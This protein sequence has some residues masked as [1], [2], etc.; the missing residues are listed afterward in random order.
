MV[1]L[2][3]SKSTIL[4]ISLGRGVMM[5]MVGTHTINSK[6][7][8]LKALIPV[9]FKMICFTFID[10][11]TPWRSLECVDGL[12]HSIHLAHSDASIDSRVDRIALPVR[13]D[14]HHQA[15]SPYLVLR[16]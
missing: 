10:G 2:R 3:R 5:T 6:M 16:G 7:N 15:L 11:C 4:S 1:S 14:S 13:Q 9:H 8:Y 12:S